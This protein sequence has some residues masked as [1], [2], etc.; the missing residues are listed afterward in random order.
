MR[1]ATKVG[2]VCGKESLGW[3]AEGGRGQESGVRGVMGQVCIQGKMP[4]PGS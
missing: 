2:W 3:E 1:P 4:P